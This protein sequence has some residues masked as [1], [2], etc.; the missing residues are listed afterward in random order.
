MEM[1]FALAFWSA[2]LRATQTHPYVRRAVAVC[3]AIP[4]VVFQL[5]VCACARARGHQAVVKWVQFGV[6]ACVPFLY[7]N[8]TQLLR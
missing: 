8:A 6:L 4:D 2:F 5:S 7:K 1:W 3:A